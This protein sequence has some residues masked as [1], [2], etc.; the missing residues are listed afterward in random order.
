MGCTEEQ[1]VALDE[2]HFRKIDL[3]DE[4]FVL[5]V[6]GYVGASTAREIAYTIFAGKGMRWLEPERGEAWMQEHSHRL[7]RMAAEF[8]AGRTPAL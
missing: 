2:L 6:D 5:N 7:G 4:V 1:K 8:M 3:A